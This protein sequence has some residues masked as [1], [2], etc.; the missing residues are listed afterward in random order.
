MLEEC[1]QIFFQFKPLF[2]TGSMHSVMHAVCTVT[3]ANANETL[4]SKE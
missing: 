3:P 1:L 4:F 2:D